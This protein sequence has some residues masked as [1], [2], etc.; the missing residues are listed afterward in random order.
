M[1]ESKELTIDLIEIEDT[2]NYEKIDL[3]TFHALQ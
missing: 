2:D 3:S 1:D